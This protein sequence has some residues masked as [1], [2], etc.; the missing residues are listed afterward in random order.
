[1]SD[2]TDFVKCSTLTVPH[3][4]YNYDE[5]K[6]QVRFN[7]KPT[8]HVLC[9]WDYAYRTARRGE[10]ETYARD[11]YRFKLRIHKVAYILNPILDREHRLK[12][13]EQRYVC[14]YTEHEDGKAKDTPP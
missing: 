6:K 8:I 12:V 2:V 4:M 14:L 10:W 1:M 5:M 3:T 9:T 13:Y 7:T 11:L